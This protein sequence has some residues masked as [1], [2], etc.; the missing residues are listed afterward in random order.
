MSNA[1]NR[2]SNVLAKPVKTVAQVLTV[3]S[4]NTTTVQHSDSSK[5]VVYGNS[6]ASGDVYIKDGEIVGQAAALPYIEIDI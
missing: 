3:N 4:N 2:L 6:V 5:S 1:Y